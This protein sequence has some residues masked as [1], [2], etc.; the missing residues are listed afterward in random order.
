M[1]GTL[2]LKRRFLEENAGSANFC[3]QKL[4]FFKKTLGTFEN[5]DR[6][7]PYLSKLPTSETNFS[8]VLVSGEILSI[9]KL[10]T[11]RVGHFL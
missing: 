4:Q 8:I 7:L 5:F 3:S 1:T 10:A 6:L 2:T 11:V 9:K